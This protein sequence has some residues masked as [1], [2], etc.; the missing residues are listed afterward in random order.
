MKKPLSLRTLCTCGHSL[1]K[2]RLLDP[3]VRD[4]AG[5]CLIGYR[6]GFA[7]SA[8]C[9]KVCHKFVPAPFVRKRIAS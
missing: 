9:A 2:H 4:K 3:D 1:G 7:T 5:D 6:A 8:S